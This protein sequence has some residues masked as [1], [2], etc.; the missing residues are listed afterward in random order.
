MN[1]GYHSKYWEMQQICLEGWNRKD[2]FELSRQELLDLNL[3][4]C[5]SRLGSDIFVTEDLMESSHF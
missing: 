5:G 2:L 1:G 3:D 4:M